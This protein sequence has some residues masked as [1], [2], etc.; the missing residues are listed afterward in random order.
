[1]LCPR[2]HGT[3]TVFDH[4]QPQPCP[5]CG[6]MGEVHCCDGLTEQPG[7]DGEAACPVDDREK[8]SDDWGC[9]PAPD[10]R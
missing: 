7:P 8:S 10:D 9:E 2:C 6:G 1:M 3:R 5:D 4:G